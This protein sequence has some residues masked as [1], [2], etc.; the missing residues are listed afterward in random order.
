MVDERE[1]LMVFVGFDLWQVG[2]VQLIAGFGKPT[3]HKVID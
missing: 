2:M 3:I 1:W